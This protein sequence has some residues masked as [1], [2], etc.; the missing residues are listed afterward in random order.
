MRWWGP[1]SAML[2]VG[3]SAGLASGETA[4][5]ARVLVAR[6][7]V[8]RLSRVVFIGMGWGARGPKGRKALRAATALARGHAAGPVQ[9]RPVNEV[10]AAGR[11][12][13]WRVKVEEDKVRAGVSLDSLIKSFHREV[14]STPFAAVMPDLSVIKTGQVIH[15]ARR[16]AAFLAQSAR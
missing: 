9:S 8:R 14:G 12:R 2:K 10:V 16:C 1:R 4:S 15:K 5:R 7:R 13:L 6:S 11:R 3:A